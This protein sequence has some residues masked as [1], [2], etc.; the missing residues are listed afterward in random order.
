MPS[1]KA[2]RPGDIVKAANGKTIEVIN[3]DAEG[4]MVLADA[5]WY[6]CEKKVSKVIDIATLTGAVIIA[7]GT[8]TAGIISNNEKL[9]T[10]IKEAGNTVG[11]RYWEL[12]NLPEFK[13][14]IKGEITDV[15]NSTGR[16]GGVITGGLFVGEFIKENTLWAHI[17]IGGTATASKTKGHIK[18]GATAFGLTTLVEF[19]KMEI[20]NNE[21]R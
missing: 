20:S 12:P 2:M 4:R 8:E 3:T 11:E 17:D 6:A 18:K 19:A 1:S 13:E 7:L 16:P 10:Q 14:M 15:I 9:T 5:V 21:K